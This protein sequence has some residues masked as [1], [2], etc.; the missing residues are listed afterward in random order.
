[1]PIEPGSR[2]RRLPGPEDPRGE[3][4]VEEGLDECGAEE[5]RAAVALEPDAE[6][7][8]QGGADGVQRWRIAGG[9]YPRQAVAGVGCEEPRDVL[10]IY[11]GCAV[12]EGAT[13]VFSEGRAFVSGECAGRLEAGFEVVLGSRE[14]EGLEPGGFPARSS[15]RRTKSRVLVTSTR[16]YLFQ[17]LLT[18][19]LSAVSHASSEAGLISTTPQ[20]GSWPVGG[21][22]AL[23]LPGG[24]ES[25]VGVAGARVLELADAADPG[26]EGGANGGEE[27]VEGGVVG[28]LGG[29][30]A[31]CADGAEV[32]R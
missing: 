7:L 4:A 11:E 25:E 27:V 29:C 12:G 32:L 19:S 30:A 28:E 18:W 6:G 3:D 24:V 5:R 2:R 13:E 20:S 1:M 10:R 14:A 31:G 22:A 26:L 21:L 9:L 16:R 17:Y 23:H 15:P 8:L